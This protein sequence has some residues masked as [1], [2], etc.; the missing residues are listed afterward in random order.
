MKLLN[1]NKCKEVNKESPPR[2]TISESNTTANHAIG[3]QKQ[4][5][6]NSVTALSKKAWATSELF[7]NHNKQ[8]MSSTQENYT[9]TLTELNSD[10]RKVGLKED[11]KQT[12]G[13]I[14]DAISEGSP[15][16]GNLRNIN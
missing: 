2:P 13:K 11:V 15:E 8:H 16:S 12:E 3:L 4:P 14:V 10:L 6:K 9:E 5:G 7:V 1:K